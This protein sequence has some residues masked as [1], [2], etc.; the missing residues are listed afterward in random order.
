MK[1]CL[2]VTGRKYLDGPVYFGVG[3]RGNKDFKGD[4][5]VGYNAVEKR[6]TAAF[7]HAMHTSKKNHTRRKLKVLINIHVE[8]IH[9]SFKNQLPLCKNQLPLLKNQLSLCNHQLP[10]NEPNNK[11]KSIAE[12]IRCNKIHFIKYENRSFMMNYYL[13]HLYKFLLYDLIEIVFLYWIDVNEN[14]LEQ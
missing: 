13:Q 11:L 8:E 10:K 5:V 12:L 9:L 7:I 3:K 14:E 4:R 6:R 1:E 2:T